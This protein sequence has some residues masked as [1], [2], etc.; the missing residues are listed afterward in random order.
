MIFINRACIPQ[1]TAFWR[2]RVLK[3]IG[4]FDEC[5]QFAMDTDFFIRILKE[6]KSLHINC[7]YANHRWHKSSKSSIKK[8]KNYR[9]FR[10]ERK[11]ILKKH[12]IQYLVFYYFRYILLPELTNVNR[13]K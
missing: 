1:Q 9:A 7:N 11:K 12:G 8:E 3:E 6:F 13:I 5:F 4:Y 2:R 10:S